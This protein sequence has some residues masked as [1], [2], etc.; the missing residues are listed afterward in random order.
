[1]KNDAQPV[2]PSQPST[3]NLTPHDHHHDH[4]HHHHHDHSH[5]H[6]HDHDHDHGFDHWQDLLPLLFSIALL[7]IGLIIDANYSHAFWSTQ[8]RLW[9][10]LVAYLP[11]AWPVLRL[12]WKNIQRGS[13][14]TEFFLMALATLGAFAIGE[15]PEGVAVMLFYTIG[16]ALQD[17]AVKK[18]K[19]NISALLSWRPQTA[20]VWRAG[21]YQ[22]VA[23]Q[24]VAIGERIRVKSGE[25]I[26]LDGQLLSE[27]ARLNMAALSGESRPQNI[28]QGEKILA[29][30][31]N[32]E[33]V[34]ELE[35]QHL[36]ADS[37]IARMLEL[38]QHAS[39]KKAKT[40]LLIRRYAK[41]YTPI[42]FYLALAL[43]F[44]PYFL[45]EQYV[46]QEWLYR[47]LVFLVISC[48]CA[49]VISIPLGYFGG[50]GAASQ[51]GL[52]FKGATYLDQISQVNT[53]LMDK[54]GTMTKG[55]FR[56]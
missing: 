40:E 10:Y 7:L 16:E 11:V 32:L 20:T 56:I 47:G 12:A 4:E 52:L 27:K 24:Q 49:L 45:V 35:V 5:D 36:F 26:P 33:Q 19:K 37:S 17:A 28:R 23:P 39:A 44:L 42:V 25:K 51:N 34:I 55:V 41:I 8:G 22:N 21:R 38:I 54:T 50:L 30:S 3:T 14:F 15:Y 31:I 46:F 18:A 9:W 29:G 6:D 53:L 48:P 1:M 43:T 13:I 2:I